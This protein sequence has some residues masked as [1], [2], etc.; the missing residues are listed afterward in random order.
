MAL[1]QLAHDFIHLVFQ[2]LFDFLPVF[3]Q[4]LCI[5][6]KYAEIWHASLYH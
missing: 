5:L 1:F 3:I 4:S 6:S 2:W